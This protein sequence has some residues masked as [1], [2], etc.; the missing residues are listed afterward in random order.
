MY[1]SFNRVIVPAF[2]CFILLN[3][4]PRLVF[5]TR[6]VDHKGPCIE[7]ICLL[8]ET[9]SNILQREVSK[10]CGFCQVLSTENLNMQPPA[11]TLPTRLV[12]SSTLR[13]TQHRSSQP[14]VHVPLVV[15]EGLPGGTR[16]TSIF[17]QKPGFHS[18]LVYVSGL[19]L[20][21]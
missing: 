16:V 12:A 11:N 9:Q 10:R 7:R 13:M 21:E 6:P 20:N 17:S 19:F 5:Q 1:C 14:V 15:R 4:T 3:S 8:L 2:Y 18:F